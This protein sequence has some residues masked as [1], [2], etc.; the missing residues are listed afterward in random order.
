M[1]GT[2]IPSTAKN[3]SMLSWRGKGAEGQQ[4]RERHWR[5]MP[6]EAENI[7]EAYSF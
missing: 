1:V 6:V 4:G 7:P 5:G 3:E 2:R